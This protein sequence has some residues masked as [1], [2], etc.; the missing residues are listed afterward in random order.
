[1]WS[2]RSWRWMWLISGILLCISGCS[3]PTQAPE[4]FFGM[5][6][7][8]LPDHPIVKLVQTIESQPYYSK[9]T[10]LEWDFAIDAKLFD[11]AF[12]WDNTLSGDIQ[13]DIQTFFAGDSVQHEILLKWTIAG[14]VEENEDVNIDIHIELT[15]L[16]VSWHQFLMIE[17]FDVDQ[18]WRKVETVSL[19]E[20]ILQT[21]IGKRLKRDNIPS[22]WYLS[23]DW[24]IDRI[25]SDMT[26]A[27]VVPDL[28]DGRYISNEWKE[29][30]VESKYTPSSEQIELTLI[31][32]QIL[33]KLV[34]SGKWVYQL[35]AEL[36]K[37]YASSFDGN[38]STKTSGRK[39]KNNLYGILTF[40]QWIILTLDAKSDISVSATR[41]KNLPA[42]ARWIAWEEIFK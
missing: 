23:A 10:T 1:M 38:R 5:A 12:S 33:A 14:E 21:Q 8:K 22:L 17:S 16:I 4:W 36:S 3:T 11:V 26:K 37:E 29:V 25:N 39:I 15:V 24:W 7:E 35:N 27:R 34:W 42:P 30:V 19:R 20:M 31:P 28:Q 18:T 9:K 41:P 2:R 40:P 32:E 6:Y 13:A